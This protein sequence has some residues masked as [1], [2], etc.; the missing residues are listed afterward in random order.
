MQCEG[1]SPNSITFISLLQACGTIQA[2]QKGEEL[3]AEIEKKGYL[4]TGTILGN[5]VLDMYAKCGE[6]VKAQRF[7]NKLG[8]LNVISWT[9]LIN[10]YSQHGH[11]KEAL[12]T[13]AWMK[14]AGFLPNAVTY[15]CVL[16][17]CGNIGTSDI[18]EKI[19]IDMARR[20]FIGTGNMLLHSLI[21]MY[22]KCGELG[23][24][25]EIFDSIVENDVMTW[26]ALISGYCQYGY[27]QK[28]LECFEHMKHEGISP[29]ALTFASVLKCCG[30][31]KALDKGEELHADTILMGFLDEDIGLANALV[32]MYVK[33]D[34]LMEAQHMFDNLSVRDVV[35]WSSL[36]AGFCQH[37]DIQEALDCLEQMME[38]GISPDAMTFI[39]IVQAC[40]GLKEVEKGMELHCEL[41]RRELLDDNAVLGNSL[42]DLYAKCGLLAKAEEVFNML[43]SRTLVAW[44]VLISGYCLHGLDED[45]LRCFERMKGEFVSPDAVTFAG[46]LGACS[47]VG[48][49]EK[50]IEIHSEIYRMRMLG[51]DTVLSSALVDMY[52]KCGLLALAKEV[53]DQLPVQDVVSWSALIT[54]YHDNGHVKEALNCFERMKHQGI[55]PDGVTFICVLDACS[56]IDAYHSGQ[57][58]YEA[59]SASFGII[60]TLEHHTCMAVLYGRAG[61]LDKSISVIK[62]TQSCHYPPLWRSFIAACRK[63]GNMTLGRLAFEH[64]L[65]EDT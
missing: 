38:G 49:A 29:T 14:R 20:G 62:K 24:A 23:K 22:A 34:A 30:S 37:Q 6:L 17:A 25:Q 47:S 7:F 26:T 11:D 28:P 4:G 53:F 59:M 12:K 46:I 32:S 33:C 35:T 48:A 8:A 3:H 64:S 36:I 21:D 43:P 19:H 63:W 42:V 39:C 2:V 18:G 51:T 58:Y 1:F 27:D 9:A 13:F 61:Q 54:G 5:A 45:A 65:Q 52:A 57:M 44:S 10:G 50:G 40:S 31:I 15:A 56:S 55:S 60:P 16:K 41:A